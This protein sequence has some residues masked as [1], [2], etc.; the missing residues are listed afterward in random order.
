[1][2]RYQVQHLIQDTYGKVT[3]S[4]LDAQLVTNHS[5]NFHKLQELAQNFYWQGKENSREFWTFPETSM[6]IHFDF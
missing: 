6:T 4:Q 3:N 1:M 2:Q 5:V